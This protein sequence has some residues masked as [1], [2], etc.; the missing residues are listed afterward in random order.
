MSS[1]IVNTRAHKALIATIAGF[2]RENGITQEEFAT[3]C[4]RDAKW[5]SAV[6][7]GDRGIQAALLPQI[8]KACDTTPLRFYKRFLAILQ[9]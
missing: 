4:R 2:L 7:T 5:A 8:A 6:L 3:R 1:G 9:T